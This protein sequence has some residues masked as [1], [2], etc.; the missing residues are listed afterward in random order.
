MTFYHYLDTVAGRLLLMSDGDRITG[1][2]WVV[3]KDAPKPTSEWVQ[4]DTPFVELTRQLQ[5][6]F[7]GGRN[8]F[9]LQYSMKGTAF[10]EEVWNELEK[11]PFGKTTTYGVIAAKIGR[12]RAV[13]A[14]GTAVGH[15]PM[16]IIV[17][18]HRVLATSGGLGGYAGGLGGKRALL[19]IENIKI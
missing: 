18:C 5:E 13:R 8:R 1:M 15:N 11:I 14:V 19:N 7:S 4:D 9:E 6:Y 2:H 16:S 3:F 17:P 12:P 10:Q